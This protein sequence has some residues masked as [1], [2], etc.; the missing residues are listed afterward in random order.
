MNELTFEKFP[1]I[2]RLKRDCVISEKIDGTNAQIYFDDQ[3][4]ILCG[5]RKRQITPEDDNAGFA[6]W[7]YTHREILFGILG[8][9]R[10]YGEWWGQGIQRSEEHTSELQSH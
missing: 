9:G 10:H 3:G 8:E 2:K 7:A 6:T 1:S 5:S 4:N